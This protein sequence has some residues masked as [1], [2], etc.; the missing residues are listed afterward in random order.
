VLFTVVTGASGAAV[1][2][3]TA[4]ATFDNRGPIERRRFAVEI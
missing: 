1:Q 4:S 2:T 3:L